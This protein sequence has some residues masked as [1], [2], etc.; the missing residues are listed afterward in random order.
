MEAEEGKR[1]FIGLE[2]EKRERIINAALREFVGGFKKASTDA[3]VREAG[4]SKGLLFH[5]FGTKE[6]LHGFLVD[7]AIGVMTS[8][9]LGLINLRQRDIIESMWQMLLLKIDLSY[10][11]PSI[12]EFLA[13]VYS[14]GRS[15]SPAFEKFGEMQEK[16]IGEVYANCDK[17][18]F[19]GD[20]NADKCIEI[21]R[22]ALSGYAEAQ[23]IREGA[24]DD[25]KPHYDRYLKETKEYLE[26]F[27]RCFY[28]EKYNR[29]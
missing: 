24:A 10:K 26:I 2:A 15:E 16:I 12:F 4:I 9:Y 20:V 19:R 8:E 29:N 28:N 5:Y 23:V 7:Y 18:L 1:K 27:R 11:Y 17:S 14:D 3:I 22:W 13:G 25:Y 21:I 6:G